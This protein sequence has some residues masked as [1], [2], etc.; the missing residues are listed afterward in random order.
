MLRS[1]S[2]TAGTIPGQAATLVPCAN[3]PRVAFLRA[4]HDRGASTTASSD[5]RFL[6]E[7]YALRL[8]LRSMRASALVAIRW[9]CE[10]V[11]SKKSQAL[12]FWVDHP[13]GIGR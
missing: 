9:R 1:P 10:A 5:D 7:L 3:P 6:T 13:I 12:H 8:A 2:K 4:L 11:R